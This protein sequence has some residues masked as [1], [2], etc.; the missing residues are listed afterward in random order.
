MRVVFFVFFKLTVGI[1]IRQPA[2]AAASA[3]CGLKPDLD[4]G[5]PPLILEPTG[6]SLCSGLANLHSLI[7]NHMCVYLAPGLAPPRHELRQHGMLNSVCTETTLSSLMRRVKRRTTRSVDATL[8]GN[9][10]QG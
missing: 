1:F 4:D 3:A 2:A 6:R 9:A 7:N 5:G 10:M 8:T